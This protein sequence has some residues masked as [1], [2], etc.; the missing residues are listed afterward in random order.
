V[1]LYVIGLWALHDAGYVWGYTGVT[2][3]QQRAGRKRIMSLYAE[4]REAS[5]EGTYSLLDDGRGHI[6]AAL[7]QS[8]FVS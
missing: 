4:Q 8:I 1:S 7:A 3:V 2:V 6:N 5:L